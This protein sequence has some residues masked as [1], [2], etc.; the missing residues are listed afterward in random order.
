MSE[1][2]ASSVNNRH[3]VDDG[4]PATSNAA[5]VVDLSGGDDSPIAVTGPPP[6]DPSSPLQDGLDCMEWYVATLPW[7]ELRPVVEGKSRAFITAF[8]THFRELKKDSKTK[9]GAAATCP[10][11]C[12]VTF[13]F[14]PVERFKGSAAH[15][16]FEAKT[17]S[18]INQCRTILGELWAEGLS[19]N[20]TA[21]KE[22][23]LEM[24]ASRPSQ[25]LPR[26]SHFGTRTHRV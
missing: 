15:T 21:R 26:L 20:R 14:Q 17:S 12:K 9:E 10:R 2:P 25:T 5:E 4:V 8:W 18:T 7:K 11:T 22:E 24:L 3:A 13:P 19:H 16:A 6:M 1:K 23:L